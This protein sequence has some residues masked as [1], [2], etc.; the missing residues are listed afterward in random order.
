MAEETDPLL[1][2]QWQVLREY[3]G[4]ELFLWPFL[5][6]TI[7]HI[8]PPSQSPMTR[9]LS[10][11]KSLPWQP[12]LRDPE[13]GDQ[14][15]LMEFST[16]HLVPTLLKHV[17]WKPFPRSRGSAWLPDLLLKVPLPGPEGQS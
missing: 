2:G 13:E 11:E 15:L 1:V 4:L 14:P 8:G 10:G 5:E 6:N 9:V 17:G 12:L 3:V 16:L 7:C